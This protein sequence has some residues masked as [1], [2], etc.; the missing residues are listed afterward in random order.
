MRFVRVGL[1]LEERCGG[2]SW[3]SRGGGKREDGVEAGGWAMQKYIGDGGVGIWCWGKG[4]LL[5]DCA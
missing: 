3:G 4:G 1:F 2:F 5:R